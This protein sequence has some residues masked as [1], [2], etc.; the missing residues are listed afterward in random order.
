MTAPVE[1]G[2][3]DYGRY[4]ARADVVLVKETGT[5]SNVIT[6]RGPFF[7]GGNTHLAFEMF[8][9]S[10]S[11]DVTFVYYQDQARTIELSQTNMSIQSANYCSMTVP[12]RGPW[13]YLILAP[14]ITPFLFNLALWTAAGPS[15][16]HPNVA[17]ASIL[18]SLDGVNIAAAA[19]RTDD[20]E[21]VWPGE[22][23]W[24]ADMP[25][26][27][28]FD[29]RLQAISASGAVT[30]LDHINQTTPQGRH[31]VFLPP[32]SLRVASHNADAGPRPIY[33]TLLA[34]PFDPGR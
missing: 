34:R 33:A 16:G 26:A 25:T 8:V 15:I 19:T 10:G 9:S 7:V 1:H 23:S 22:A 28:T 30:L 11:V 29:I 3:P 17:G 21:Y 32:M 5:V 27:T 24:S 6:T 31:T 12:V 14:S 13:L 2:Y 20:L 18:L 4:S